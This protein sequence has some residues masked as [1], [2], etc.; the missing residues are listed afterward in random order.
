MLAS[1]G[2]TPRWG[3]PWTEAGRGRC[4]LLVE[5]LIAQLPVDQRPTDDAEADWLARASRLG[6]GEVLE[7]PDPHARGRQRVGN[8][9]L[10]SRS[11]SCSRI[12]PPSRSRRQLDI[13]SLPVIWSGL[14]F[15]DAGSNASITWSS[16][17]DL[18]GRS[19]MVGMT[20]PLGQLLSAR[21]S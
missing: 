5:G 11:T 20:Q 1:A 15:L 4:R 7:E 16:V 6:L 14:A 19:A 9:H 2:R 8:S 13:W 12:A 18:D 21:R 10:R 17:A 3:P